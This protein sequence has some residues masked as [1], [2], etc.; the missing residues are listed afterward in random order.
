MSHIIESYFKIEEI[1]PIQIND[2]LKC[3]LHLLTEFCLR[4]SIRETT[5][6]QTQLKPIYA[7]AETLSK[8]VNAK[9]L[10]KNCLKTNYYVK[11]QVQVVITR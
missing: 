8:L 10:L 9:L 4:D 6:F 1:N 3:W 5:K 2:L 11:Y 7:Q